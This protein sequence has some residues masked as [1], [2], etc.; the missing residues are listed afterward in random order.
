MSPT[1]GG[2]S[3]Q[4]AQSLA[5]IDAEANRLFGEFAIGAG[6]SEA[7]GFES[8][9]A[10]QERLAQQESQEFFTPKFNLLTGTRRRGD[11]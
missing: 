3:Q 6:Q 2:V 1:L 8:L 10:L 5:Q 7:A 4:I 11:F 9:A